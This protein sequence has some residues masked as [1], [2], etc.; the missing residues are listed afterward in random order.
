MSNCS[1]KILLLQ[2]SNISQDQIDQLYKMTYRKE[3]KEQY[4]PLF[5]SS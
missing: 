3:G 4:R 1:L 2:I 5:F